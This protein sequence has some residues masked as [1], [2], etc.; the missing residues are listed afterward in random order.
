MFTTM[1][2]QLLS[3][4]TFL[5]RLGVGVT[6]YQAGMHAA[7][8]VS[9]GVLTVQLERCDAACTSFMEALAERELLAAAVL[10]EAHIVATMGSFRLRAAQVL[11]TLRVLRERRRPVHVLLLTATVT[12]EDLAALVAALGKGFVQVIG[13]HAAAPPRI[14]HVELDRKSG[15]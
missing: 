2:A 14:L 8:G 6:R 4:E 12:A 1:L 10:D 9:P 5:R 3:I 7:A 11:T 13:Q 15:G